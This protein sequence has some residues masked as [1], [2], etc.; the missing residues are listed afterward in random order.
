MR[1]SYSRGLIARSQSRIETNMVGWIANQSRR[2]NQPVTT[3]KAQFDNLPPIPFESL[4][5]APSDPARAP[6]LRRR[7][8][9]HTAALPPTADLMAVQVGQER[10]C[11]VDIT[12][13][14]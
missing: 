4:L 9:S 13:E 1:H 6:V 2:A 14:S 5:A 11:R 3:K 7:P 8:V 10:N 12:V